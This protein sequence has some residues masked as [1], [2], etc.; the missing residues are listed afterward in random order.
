MAQMEWQKADELARQHEAYA[1]QLARAA[2]DAREQA[3][4]LG[5]SGSPEDVQDEM[6]ADQAAVNNKAREAQ[7]ARDAAARAQQKAKD[8]LARVAKLEDAMKPGGAME[9]LLQV[10]QAIDKA[11][12]AKSRVATAKLKVEGLQSLLAKLTAELEDAMREV[13]TRKGEAAAEDA[14][15]ADAVKRSMGLQDE[16]GLHLA[17]EGFD[18]ATIHMSPESAKQAIEDAKK[19]AAQAQALAKAA[20]DKASK[21]A[22][23]AQAVNNTMQQ[24]LQNLYSMPDLDELDE[25]A[26]NA[27]LSA[28]TARANADSLGPL[29]RSYLK[30][31]QAAHDKASGMGEQAT[32]QKKLADQERQYAE[33]APY[34]NKLPPGW[35]SQVDPVTGKTYYI[36]PTGETMWDL[37]AAGANAKA[38]KNRAAQLEQ[39]AHKALDDAKKAEADARKMDELVNMLERTMQERAML[40]ENVAQVRNTASVYQADVEA[41]VVKVEEGFDSANPDSQMDASEANVGQPEQSYA[42]MQPDPAY[43]EQQQQA[44]QRFHQQAA[45]HRQFKLQKESESI[46]PNFCQMLKGV[47]W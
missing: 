21:A 12:L 34:G 28:D 44:Y 32:K 35:Q 38:D 46:G 26:D 2:E 27:R 11:N 23:Q 13:D 3:A 9:K 19:Q 41:M 37:P 22:D 15:A 33:L 39:D 24:R 20:A 8:L 29:V 42:E 17:G 43:A 5:I 16:L 47:L 10:Q 7:K 14:A 36:S 31:A 30:Y 6:E 25:A 40:E 1:D 45:Y 18:G 4:A